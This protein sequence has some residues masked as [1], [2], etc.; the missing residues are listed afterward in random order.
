MNGFSQHE[1]MALSS[2]K[3]ARTVEGV[4]EYLLCRPCRD[5]GLV[6]F[7]GVLPLTLG[8]CQSGSLAVPEEK[9]G[10]CKIIA[11]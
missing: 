7:L 1:R 11:W 5:L 2:A 9:V 8:K 6:C 4:E 3:E 10:E